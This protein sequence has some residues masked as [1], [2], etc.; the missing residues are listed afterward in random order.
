VAD[1]PDAIDLGR[2]G[3][4][5]GR[6]KDVW[7]RPTLLALA[8]L[9]PVLALFNVFGQRPTTSNA[10]GPAAK[11]SVYAPTKLRGG[12]LWEGAST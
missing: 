1:P 11:L 12:L 3:D 2:D 10:S 8:T 5:R 6:R 7:V 9:V 4:L